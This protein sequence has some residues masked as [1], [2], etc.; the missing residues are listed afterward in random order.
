MDLDNCKML[1]L[2]ERLKIEKKIST[3]TKNILWIGH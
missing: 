3:Q 1:I 2:N